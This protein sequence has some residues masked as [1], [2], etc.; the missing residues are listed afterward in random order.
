M[1]IYRGFN[2]IGRDFGPYK[3]KD[4]SLVVRD[5]LNHLHMRKGEKLHNPKF[6]SIIW[7]S[8]FEPLTPALKEAIRVDVDRIARYDPRIRVVDRVDVTEYQNGLR[9]DLQITFSTNNETV[10]LSL[11]FDREAQNASLFA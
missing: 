11:Q 8:L 6:G 9:V 1:S 7:Q 10:N 3:L 4:N 5:F 2:T